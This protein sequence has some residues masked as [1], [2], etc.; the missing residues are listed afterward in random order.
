[1]NRLLS[2]IPFEQLLIGQLV[3][4]RKTGVLGAIA[5]LTPKQV[6]DDDNYMTINWL[7]G[8]KSPGLYHFDCGH[9][10]AL[11]FEEPA[12]DQKMDYGTSHL[13]PADDAR[14]PTWAEQRATRGF[15]DTELWNLDRTFA[16]VMYP[17]LVAYRESR[18]VRNDEVLNTI[19]D[20]LAL[21]AGDAYFDL[22]DDE[23]H[24]LEEALVLFGQHIT[25]FWI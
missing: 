16:R 2:Q 12:K 1:M 6:Q 14:Q 22:S 24:Q 17:R 19:I 3:C 8:N 13:V 9:I 10:D 23:Q 25:R 15:D 4:S 5:S 11:Y 20:G 7:N 21:M 18:A